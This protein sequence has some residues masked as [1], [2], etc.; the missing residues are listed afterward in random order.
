MTVPELPS[1]A[2][3]ARDQ[4]LAAVAAE[5]QAL[6]AKQSGKCAEA[7]ETLARAFTLLTS[8]SPAV[9]PASRNLTVGHGLNAA[10]GGYVD[11]IA[12]GIIDPAKVTR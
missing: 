7:L 5:A 2:V 1:A 3:D 4:L 11:M 9:A 10:S 8:G 12:E 6:T